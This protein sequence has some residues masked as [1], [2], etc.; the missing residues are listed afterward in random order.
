MRTSF[1]RLVACALLWLRDS[2][3]LCV[4]NIF[5]EDLSF[6]DTQSKQAILSERVDNSQPWLPVCTSGKVNSSLP[7]DTSLGNQDS[8]MPAHLSSPTKVTSSCPGT[9]FGPL[10]PKLSAETDRFLADTYEDERILFSDDFFMSPL[11][12][13]DDLIRKILEEDVRN[14]MGVGVNES[15]VKSAADKVNQE[16]LAAKA[17]SVKYIKDW[18]TRRSRLIQELLF[19]VR[20]D[21]TAQEG[22]GVFP[23]MVAEVFLSHRNSR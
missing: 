8:P 11:Q 12:T 1:A 5:E 9:H 22:S 3:F 21:S 14:Q 13:G 2:N 7:C 16:C 10:P 17:A 20:G 15:K 19:A 23:E 6:P 18:D 4:R